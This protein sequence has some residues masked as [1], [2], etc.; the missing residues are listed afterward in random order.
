MS[1]EEILGIVNQYLPTITSIA[2]IIFVIWKTLRTIGQGLAD[3]FKK[4]DSAVADQNKK[5]EEVND[6][7]QRVEQKYNELL[8]EIT[9]IYHQ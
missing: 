7:L 5:L 4:T 9:K 6:Q 3:I 2:G 8:T 1:F